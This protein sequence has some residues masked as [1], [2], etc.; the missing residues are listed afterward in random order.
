MLKRTGGDLMP[1]QLQSLA[2]VKWPERERTKATLD[3]VEREKEKE[4][5]RE[6]ETTVLAIARAMDVL[7]IVIM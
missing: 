7:I 5:E 2:G 3:R 1:S 6:R 4:R